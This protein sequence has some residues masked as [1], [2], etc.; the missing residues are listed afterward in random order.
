MTY[1][2]IVMSL[3]GDEYSPELNDDQMFDVAVVA[4]DIAFGEWPGEFVRA[5]QIDYDTMTVTSLTQTVLELIAA[6]RRSAA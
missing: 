1:L 2:H 5:S 4:R 3:G 6:N